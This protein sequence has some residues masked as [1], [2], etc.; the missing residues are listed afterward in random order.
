MQRASRDLPMG[1]EGIRGE[2]LDRCNACGGEFCTHQ[3]LRRLL[4][5]H[6]PASNAPARVYVRPSPLSDPMRYRK[7]AACHEM[8]LRKNFR[9]TSGIIVDVCSAHGIWFDGGELGMVFEFVAT[10]AFAKAE[11]ESTRRAEDR[12]RLDEFA[13]DLRKAGPVHYLG[14]HMGAPTEGLADLA[15]LVP[16]LDDD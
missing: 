6:A 9:E 11:R 12:R 7:C 3:A 15:M 5:A 4:F 8:M 14:S 1:S 2:T 13:R 16:D 10:G